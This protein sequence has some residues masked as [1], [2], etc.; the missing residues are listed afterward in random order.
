[1]G[2]PVSLLPEVNRVQPVQELIGLAY[3]SATQRPQPKSPKSNTIRPNPPNLLHPPSC[4][5]STGEPPPMRV[6]STGEPLPPRVHTTVHHHRA[7]TQRSAPQLCSHPPFSPAVVLQ[8]TSVRVRAPW[9]PTLGQ[10]RP[11][12]PLHATE[13]HPR[14]PPQFHIAICP[15]HTRQQSIAFKIERAPRWYHGVMRIQEGGITAATNIR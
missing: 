3:P 13:S 2:P 12:T 11:E 6:H 1:M 7:P 8:T 15:T 10:A 4:V 14:T 9:Q 5:H